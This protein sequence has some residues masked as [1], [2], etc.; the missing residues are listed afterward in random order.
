[1]PKGQR[2][3]RA[4]KNIIC[5]VYAFFEEQH[6][7]SRACAPAKLSTKTAWATR[8]SLRTVERVLAIKR[9]SSGAAFESPSKRY[10]ASRVCIVVDDTWYKEYNSPVL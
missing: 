3:R 7:K 2:L 1:M 8:Y 4:T 10:K 6:K 9:A 5:N